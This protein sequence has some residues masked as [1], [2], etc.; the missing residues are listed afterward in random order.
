MTSADRDGTDRVEVG[1]VIKPHGLRGEVVVHV[2]SDVDDRFAPG[3]EVWVDG[4]AS[5]IATSRPHQGRPLVRFAHVPDRTAAELLRGA[6]IE[7]APV[8]AVELD[9]YLV[10]ELIGVHVL[11]ADGALLGT[12]TGLVEM[13]AIAGYDLLEVAA[14]DGRSWLLPAADELVEAVEGA[15]GLHLVMTELPEGL[16]DIGS[17]PAAERE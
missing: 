1:R 12:V 9:T 2:V 17:A 10:S 7:A 15:D 5:T 16:L 6:L 3:V 4:V 14:P 13:P 11:D 8:D